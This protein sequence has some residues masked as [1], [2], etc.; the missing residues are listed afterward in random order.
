MPR[1]G[2]AVDK[3]CRRGI[4]NLFLDRASR[5]ESQLLR[6]YYPGLWAKSGR[7]ISPAF[8]ES[9]GSHAQAGFAEEARRKFNGDI[10]HFWRLAAQAASSFQERSQP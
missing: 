4:G 3:R 8:A 5:A 2:Q 10:L 9:Q 1:C 7:T 6:G